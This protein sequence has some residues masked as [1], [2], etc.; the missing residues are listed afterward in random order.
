VLGRSVRAV[1]RRQPVPYVEQLM[2]E[3][4]EIRAA[5]V[6]VLKRS[7]I[8]YYD[9]NEGSSGI[10]W[11]GYHKYWWASSND[12]DALQADRMSLLGKARDFR[13]R[14]ELLFPHPTPE[15]SKRH[16]EALD[17]LG[18]WL[19]RDERDHSIPATIP[20]AIEALNASVA[21]LTKAKELLPGDKFATRLT[22]DTYSTT[23]TWPS[24]PRSSAVATWLMCCRSCFARSTTRSESGT[25]RCARRPRRLT[26]A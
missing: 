4:E 19:R 22:V 13:T 11:L 23:R 3:L 20:A 9:P 24:S 7:Q 8:D 10:L 25:S 6:E 17:H 5:F 21:V 18:R 15:I 12:D 2:A 16:R 1:T 26:G 14:F